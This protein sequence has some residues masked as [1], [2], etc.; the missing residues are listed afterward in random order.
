MRALTCPLLARLGPGIPT[1][2]SSS[3]VVG[4][5]ESKIGRAG[6]V[7]TKT[8]RAL[9]ADPLLAFF[10]SLLTTPEAAGAF[11]GAL[12]PTSRHTKKNKKVTVSVLYCNVWRTVFVPEKL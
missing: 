3:F 7:T 4:T 9:R 6:H 10:L 5:L 2:A 11:V 1:S 12:Y 8:K